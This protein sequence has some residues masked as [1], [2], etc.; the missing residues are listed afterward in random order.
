MGDLLFIM[1]AEDQAAQLSATIGGRLVRWV[2]NGAHNIPQRKIKDLVGSTNT[3]RSNV[4]AELK[5]GYKHLFFFGHGV[6]TALT[7]SGNAC[8]DTTNI[9]SLPSTAIVVAV[10][11]Y[12]RSGLGVSSTIASGPTSGPTVTA[13]LGWEDELPI[14]SQ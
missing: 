8:V 11:C 5:K 4:D 2:R 3:S 6:T 10:A 14:P 1:P 7:E 9:S 12:S 13:Y